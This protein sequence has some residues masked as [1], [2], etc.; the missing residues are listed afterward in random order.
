MFWGSFTPRVYTRVN[1][2]PHEMDFALIASGGILSGEVDM[3]FGESKSGTAL[4]EEERRKLKLFG[5]ATDAYMCF[6]TMADDFSE[7]DKTFFRE[8]VDSKIKVIMAVLAQPPR[9]VAVLGEDRLVYKLGADKIE[10]ILTK[11]GLRTP[12]RFGCGY[13]DEDFTRLLARKAYVECS[14]S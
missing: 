3:I 2:E 9:T 5:Q 10:E 1:G 4:T 7:A 11:H 6:C 14:D 8:L 13:T 12:R